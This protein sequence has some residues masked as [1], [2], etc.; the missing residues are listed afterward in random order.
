[1]PDGDAEQSA[2]TG[3]TRAGTAAQQD[4][5]PLW[6]VALALLLAAAALW[7]SSGLT[8]IDV[9]FGT[10]VDGHLTDDLSGSELVSWQVP[11]ALFSL[12]AVAATLATRGVLRRVLGV[13]VALVGVW[14]LVLTF[15]GAAYDV[16]WSGTAPG[17]EGSAAKPERTI[18]GPVTSAAGGVLLVLGGALLAVRGQRMA[19][20]GARYSA[21]GG[22][23]KASDPDMELW[24]ALSD[25]D[26]PTTRGEP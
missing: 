15:D 12:A 2:A 18:W 24:D 4:K 22:K 6:I 21:P 5:R 26:D 20:M 3:T 8:W 13:L 25:G 23:T 19:R 16:A 1:M 11:I 17:Y 7:G 9:P 10:K 14:V